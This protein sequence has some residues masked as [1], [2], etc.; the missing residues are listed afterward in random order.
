MKASPCLTCTRVEDPRNCENKKCQPWRNWFVARWDAIRS[1]ARAEM[2][3]TPQKVGVPLDG[4]TYAAPHQVKKYLQED[5]CDKCLCPKDLCRLP[6]RLKNNWE[7]A[8]KD[9]LL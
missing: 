1:S 9:V 6:C 2:E 5:P 3:Q 8:R 7:K 4:Q